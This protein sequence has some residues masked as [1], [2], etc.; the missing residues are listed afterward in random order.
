MCTDTTEYYVTLPTKLGHAHHRL[1]EQ[2]LSSKQRTYDRQS[3]ALWTTDSRGKP[4]EK[5][6]F[7]VFYV[8]FLPPG[9]VVPL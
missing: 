6:S 1:V 4:L 7:R 2:V 9:D 3:Q 8:H 5:I